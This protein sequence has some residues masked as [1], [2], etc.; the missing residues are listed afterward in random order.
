MSAPE[1]PGADSKKP[2][3]LLVIGDSDFAN[4]EFLQFARYLPFYQGGGQML[5]NAI[6]WTLEDETL[7]PVRTKNV[8]VRPITVDSDAKVA[9]IKV[10][11]IACVPLAFIGFGL[12]R[13]R[14]RRARRSSQTL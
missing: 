7:T 2:V 4:D 6:G 13:W 11:N 8:G 9:L 3:R 10:I 5:F 1:T 12:V 14:L